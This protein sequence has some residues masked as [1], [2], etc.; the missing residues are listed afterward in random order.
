[1]IPH[2]LKYRHHDGMSLGRFELKGLHT[3]NK[4]V[5]YFHFLPHIVIPEETPNQMK[6]RRFCSRLYNRKFKNPL[7]EIATYSSAEGE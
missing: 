7:R 2:P 3:I 6:W 1:M 5:L 4:E